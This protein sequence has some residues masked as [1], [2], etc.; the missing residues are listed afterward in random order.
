MRKIKLLKNT[1]SSLTFQ[2]TTLICGF[3]LPKLILN[4]YG[5]EVNG[6]VGSITQ[7]LQ[8]IAFLEL[9]VGAVVQSSLYR[10]LANNNEKL[11]SKIYSSANSYFKKIGLIL[12]IYIFILIF[13]YPSIINQNIDYLYS[14]TL[15]IAIGINF[16]S[17]YYFGMVDR[18]LLTADQR[19]YIQYNIQTISLII[20]TVLCY[21]LI[22]NGSSIQI[23]K[24]ATSIIYLSR[25]FFLK[26]YVSV[27][28]KID[29]R[30]KYNEEPI[31][32]K[33]NGIAQHFASVILNSTDIIILTM[34][35][36]LSEVSVYTVYNLIVSGVK[37]LFT[38]L[39]AGIQ[40][41]VGEL[42]AKEDYNKLKSFFSW[43]E[44]IL[45]TTVVFIFG[46]TANLAV[47][48]VAVYTAT[49]NDANYILPLFSL[50]L[51]IAHAM[52]CIRLPYNIMIL[53]GGH[54]RETQKNYFIAAILNI[55]ISLILVINFG[56]IG[57]AIGT[58][59]ALSYQTIWMAW[60]NSK[61]FIKWPFK[62]FLKQLLVNL[63]TF[64]LGYLLAKYL[65]AL[66]TLSFLSWII[67][68]F[69]V[70]AVW[71][72][73]IVLVNMIFYR[74]HLMRLKNKLKLYISNSLQ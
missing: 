48:F 17:Q 72:T 4:H 1:V 20:N 31:N 62:N 37:N 63:I 49:V 34:F 71:I 5:S 56:L 8:I 22:I 15:I 52:H 40:S 2:I 9:G 41:L 57:V 33:W 45:H 59:I 39:T 21:I 46:C 64:S 61:E 27:H 38:S 10:P 12:I 7:F 25:P 16:F 24:F 11:I 42:L 29:K 44:W 55:V 3:I 26:Y 14:G 47:P 18:L 67:L 36:T 66:N 69:K 35:S 73:V 23:V 70:A 74:D 19:G 68:G 58:L 60:Y 6:L 65:I 13:I 28:Y 30:I 32:Q 43:L 51:T 53:A 50:F 54:Y